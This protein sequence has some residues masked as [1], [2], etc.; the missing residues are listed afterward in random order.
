LYANYGYQL[1]GELT[2]PSAFAQKTLGHN[3]ASTSF[4]YGWQKVDMVIRGKKSISSQV[5]QQIAE[6]DAKIAECCD[7]KQQQQPQQQPQQQAG[8]AQP[9][10]QPQPQP[11]QPA[12]A[13]KMIALP[14]LG[15]GF[16]NV[17][18]KKWG[19]VRGG[20]KAFKEQKRLEK[21]TDWVRTVL[22]PASVDLVK[23]NTGY[24]KL[25][26]VRKTTI[27]KYMNQ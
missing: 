14:K 23:I 27:S 8:N 24:A 20:D 6:Q 15:G 7:A 22:V 3:S 10:P 25:I 13:I 12:G 1:Y 2:Q 11:P 26:G 16:V 17:A 18:K 5:S 4:N 9:Q 21:Y 19:R